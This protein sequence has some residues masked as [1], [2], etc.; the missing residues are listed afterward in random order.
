MLEKLR[1]VFKLK[2]FRPLQLE[3]VN[4]T[5]SAKDCICIMPTGG[6]KSLCFQLPA[7]C[8]ANCVTLVVS[9]LVSLVEDQL[10]MLHEFGIQ[11][12]TLNGSS[13]KEKV[14]Q[15]HE[16]MLDKAN[17]QLRLLYVTPEKLAKS[18]MFMNKLQRM[19]E[20]GRFKR[21]VVDE[22]SKN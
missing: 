19:Y 2:S 22:V 3:T 21:L 20:L 7:V 16:A 1:T 18:K 9:P 6:G 14:K 11:A 8:D 13:S 12:D 17:T 5:M 4:V 15:I 10:W